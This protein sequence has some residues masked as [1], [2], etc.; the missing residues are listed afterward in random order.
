MRKNY[1]R[2]SCKKK[3]EVI[4]SERK[5]TNTLHRETAQSEYH[6]GNDLPQEEFPKS[7][8]TFLPRRLN[9]YLSGVSGTVLNTLCSSH[10]NPVRYFVPVSQSQK[11]G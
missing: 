5:I 10:A 9:T 11:R 2:N 1:E 7:E 4:E 3:K 6:W 8:L